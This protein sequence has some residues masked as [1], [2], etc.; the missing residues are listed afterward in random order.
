MKIPEIFPDIDMPKS[1]V[2]SL[3]SQ[4]R[5]LKAL[6]QSLSPKYES[7]APYLNFQTEAVTNHMGHPTTTQ[8]KL[9]EV[10]VVK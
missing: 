10:G 2:L 9:F 6:V 8:A 7:K 3:K 5:R 1:E 4:G